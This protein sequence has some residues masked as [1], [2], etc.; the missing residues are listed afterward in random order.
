LIF[1]CFVY[2]K[3][4]IQVF[5]M[6]MLLYK[7]ICPDIAEYCFR[8]YYQR[9]VVPRVFSSYMTINNIRNTYLFS[10]DGSTIYVDLVT[11]QLVNQNPARIA[12]E[13]IVAQ[14][15]RNKRIDFKFTF[16]GRLFVW[17]YRYTR[18]NNMS[19]LYLV[20]RPRLD[21]ASSDVR[22]G[23]RSVVVLYDDMLGSNI[24]VCER[25]EKVPDGI[26]D[27]AGDSYIIVV[28][29]EEPDEEDSIND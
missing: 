28:K 7:N 12:V 19:E 29:N 20:G 9:Y 15:G 1:R 4:T 17:R 25:R 3:N 11:G 27:E 23:T 8:L 26:V 16:N 18:A 14:L 21:E 10:I 22:R 6:F 13:S 2:L 24:I 5:V